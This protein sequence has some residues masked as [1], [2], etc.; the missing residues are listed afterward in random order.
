MAAFDPSAYFQQQFD[1]LSKQ[2]RS[3]NLALVA[4]VKP[5]LLTLLQQYKL[6]LPLATHQERTI[7]AGTLLASNLG[8]H[9]T[10]LRQCFTPILE[11]ANTKGLAAKGLNALRL[12]VQA[13]F[14][15]VECSF[16]LLMARD[17]RI[18]H[19]HSTK[20]VCDLLRRVREGLGACVKHEELYWLV[21]N[22]TRLAYK[23]CAT[24]MRPERAAD[25]IETLGWCALCMEGML[26][27][28]APRFCSW[29]VQLYTALCHCYEAAGMPDGAAKAVA[30]AL[31]RHEWL[32][33]L[34]RHDPVPQTAETDALYRSVERQLGALQFKYTTCREPA[35]A[36]KAFDLEAAFGSS[37]EAQLTCL[38]EALSDYTSDHRPLAHAPPTDERVELVKELFECAMERASPALG[39]LMTHEEAKASVAA[40][41]EVK[42]AA[43]VAARDTAKASKDTA[44]A[45]AAADAAAGEDG[46]AADDPLTTS[47]AEAL[48]ASEEATA[49]AEAAAT[50]LDEVVEAEKVA[51]EAAATA[52]EALPL[53]VH[54]ALLRVACKSELWDNV[55]IM[56]PSAK[57]RQLVS[58]HRPLG[59][60]IL[61]TFPAL[62][63]C[64]PRGR[65]VET[66]RAAGAC[67]QG[68]SSAHRK[69]AGGRWRRH[70][71]DGAAR[72]GVRVQP[73]ELQRWGEHAVLHRSGCDHRTQGRGRQRI[74]AS[75]G[76]TGRAR[77]RR[78]V[79][80]CLPP[81][82]LPGN[83][84]RRR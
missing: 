32:K 41:Q 72:G 51:A 3:T 56:A 14:G 25:A 2:A 65:W 84:R 75:V 80:R 43:D 77:G 79:D 83:G 27:L 23:L 61:A 10:A 42:A 6:K 49:A 17:A 58:T 40:A 68:T 44:A 22:G 16:Q 33:K 39:S 63:A 54:V 52:Q 31:E 73:S 62:L 12:R 69:H 67:G 1:S 70:G 26:P 8:E 34:D 82:C 48:A 64:S 37:A 11:T 15:S 35:G 9:E 55:D 60:P 45:K 74:A 66:A 20:T 28:L 29:R 47:A 59:H 24:L 36:V 5:K 81:E 30:H 18:E 50:A 7:E 13:D 38:L 53:P 57:V 21:L 4:Q 71:D 19:D 46:V 78:H 76:Y